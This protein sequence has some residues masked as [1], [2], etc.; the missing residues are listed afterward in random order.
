VPN[1]AFQRK[2]LKDERKIELHSHPENSSLLD[3]DDDDDDDDEE[4]YLP[5]LVV[6]VSPPEDEFTIVGIIHVLVVVYK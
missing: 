3:D 6:V 4:G 5:S 1:Q 2:A